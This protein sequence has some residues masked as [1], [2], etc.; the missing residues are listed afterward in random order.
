MHAASRSAIAALA[1]VGA[2]GTWVIVGAG[3]AAAAPVA[4]TVAPR[5][6]RRTR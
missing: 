1:V 5:A 3:Q 2:L 4:G 6:A